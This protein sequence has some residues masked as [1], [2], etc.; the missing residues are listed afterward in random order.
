[1]LDQTVTSA[2]KRA[3]FK[4]AL[5]DAEILQLPGA[6]SPLCAR[7]IEAKGFGGFYISGAVLSADLGLPD[8]GLTTAGEV[9]GRAGQMTSASNLPALLD[10]DTGFGEPANVA[11]TV[12]QIEAAGIAACHI[13]DQ[14]MPK[15]CGHLDNKTLVPVHDMVR[16]IRAAAG[17]KRSSDFTLVAR[18]DAVGTEGLEAAAERARAYVAAGA[19]AIFADALA[20]EHD[21]KVFRR[22]V[23]VP[24]IANMTEFG[25]NRLLDKGT[26]QDLGYNAV[27]YPVTMLRLAMHAMEEGLDVIA[28]DGTQLGLVGR[29]QHRAELYELLN[30][31]AYGTYDATIANFTVPHAAKPGDLE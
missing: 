19:D 7:L 21:F 6:I 18:T 9:I 16:K 1:M 14:V 15:R 31:K 5:H 26:L 3:A 24:L 13:E 22:A 20:D 11:R 29:M 4:E 25:K 12:A 10:A 2:G 27:L 23:D 28:R 8:I 30:Y 17:A